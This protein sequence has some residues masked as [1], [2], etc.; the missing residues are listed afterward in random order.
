LTVR[1]QHTGEGLLFAPSALALRRD[2]TPG[3]LGAGWLTVRT[4]R[5]LTLDGGRTILASS[6]PL[7]G[8][9]AIP[10]VLSVAKEPEAAKADPLAW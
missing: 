8:Q 9:L 5:R 3:A 4:R 10:A 6:A 2:G 7:H 1:A